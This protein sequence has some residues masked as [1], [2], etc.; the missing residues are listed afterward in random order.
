MD[1]NY[2]RGQEEQRRLLARH[3]FDHWPTDGELIGYLIDLDDKLDALCDALGFSVIRDCRGRWCV[4]R[5]SQV[6]CSGDYYGC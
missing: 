3:G 4:C 6:D 5:T 2:F 1:A